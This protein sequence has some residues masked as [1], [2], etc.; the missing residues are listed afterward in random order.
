MCHGYEMLL[1]CDNGSK[2]MGTV[3]LVAFMLERQGFG[4][5]LNANGWIFKRV[6]PRC[7]RMCIYVTMFYMNCFMKWVYINLVYYVV[8]MTGIFSLDLFGLTIAFKMNAFQVNF[9]LGSLAWEEY[10]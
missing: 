8:T 2:R 9:I 10:S 4:L 6:M 7:Q 3:I 1:I 5:C